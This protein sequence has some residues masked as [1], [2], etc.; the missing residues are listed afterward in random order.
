MTDIINITNDLEYIETID[1]SYIE[2]TNKNIME[3]IEI[4]EIIENT[5]NI[6]E[7]CIICF[8]EKPIEEFV[9]LNCNENH[10]LC[11]NCYQKL[12]KCPICLKKFNPETIVVI[13]NQPQQNIQR[14]MI[15]SYS[16]VD[17]NI[18]CKLFCFT[19]ISIF[20]GMLFYIALYPAH[21]SHNDS[22]NQSNDDKI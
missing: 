6:K 14:N 18:I 1:M 12:D 3:N 10:K 13:Q 7:E 21:H 16:E 20:L 2:I 9:I 15:I 11:M 4:I 17:L 22:T 19:T 5:E 8:Y